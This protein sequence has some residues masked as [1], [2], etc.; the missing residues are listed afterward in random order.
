MNA[1][2]IT[3]SCISEVQSEPIK[4]RDTNSVQKLALQFIVNKSQHSYMRYD[5]YIHWSLSVN[6]PQGINLDIGVL[7]NKAT[8]KQTLCRSEVTVYTTCS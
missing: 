4:G 2:I 7:Y 1:C 5:V 6:H 3:G 8:L